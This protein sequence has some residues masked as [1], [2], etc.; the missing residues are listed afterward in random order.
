MLTWEDDG[1]RLQQLQVDL[2][3]LPG[4]LAGQVSCAGGLSLIL[5]TQQLSKQVRRP[6]GVVS[7]GAAVTC[8][9]TG[10]TTER[11]LV[12]DEELLWFEGRC[13]ACYK[14]EDKNVS[15]NSGF[16]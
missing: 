5:G 11:D 16:P 4:H 7:S 10:W 12:T 15:G 3:H 2:Q 6:V 9:D 1:P 14:R 13:S 8:G